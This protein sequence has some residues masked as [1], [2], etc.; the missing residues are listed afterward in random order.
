MPAQHGDPLPAA[1]YA[2]VSSDSQDVNNSIEAQLSEC[3]QY[4]KQ[5]NLAVVRV[6]TDEAE[7]G[8]KSNRPEFQR[9][10]SDATGPDSP[11]QVI[12][13]WKLSRFSRDRFDN[14]VYKHRI[15]KRGL[16]IV[17]VKE[18][19]DDGPAGEMT[20]AI[21]EAMDAYYSANLG[22]EVRR[23]QRQVALRGF[24][25]GRTAPFGLRIVKVREPHGNAVHNKLEPDPPRDRTVRRIFDEAIAGR[26]GEEIRAGLIRDGVPSPKGGKWAASTIHTILHNLCYAGYVVWSASNKAGDEPLVVPDCH[27]AIVSRAEFDL[28]AQVLASKAKKVANPPADGQ[29][30]HGERAAE[31]LAVRRQPDCQAQQEQV[32]P[33]LYVPHQAA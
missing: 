16:R 13:V 10:V 18:P 1:I 7:S 32:V 31:V 4:A 30:P 11:F 8:T 24:Y 27:P 3:R 25:P 26:S 22:Q 23:G 28:A 15:K 21:L 14:A 6:Y 29:C 9:M 33:L 5:H 12:L 2:R 19:I 20:E 17:S